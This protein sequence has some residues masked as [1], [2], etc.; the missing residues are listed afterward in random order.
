MRTPIFAR[1]G[2][3]VGRART[4]TAHTAFG[5]D[6]TIGDGLAFSVRRRD[7]CATI[8]RDDKSV[9]KAGVTLGA[10]E[11]GQSRW[12]SRLL[13][14]GLLLLLLAPFGYA[15]GRALVELDGPSP[16]L[17]RA[18]V[19]TQGI[20]ELPEG[21][22]VWRVVRR[23]APALGDAKVGRRVTSF[24]LAT[25]E[26]I[27]ITDAHDDGTFEDVARLAPGESYLTEN[28]TRQIRASLSGE[29]TQYLAIELVPAERGT[30]IGNGELLFVSDPFV[31]PAGQ[32]DLDL[33]RNVLVAGD[34]AQVPN[35]DGQI[36]V[37]A[38]DGAID[39]L[40]DRSGD[41]VIQAGE[42]A[43]FNAEEIEI[44]PAESVHG[45][46]RDELVA[47]TSALQAETPAAAYVIAVIGAEVPKTGETPSPSA[48]SGTIFFP[49][50]TPVGSTPGEPT[51]IAT[52][53]G[54]IGVRGRLCG[55]GVTIE[56]ISDAACPVIGDGFDM[57]LNNDP[58]GLTFSDATL[59]DGIWSWSGLPLDSY[60]LTTTRFPAAATDYLIPG[61]A[62]VG[63][64]PASGYT[65]TIDPTA[66]EIVLTA[67][68]LQPAQRATTSTTTITISICGWQNNAPANCQS[69]AESEVD[70]QPSL[71]S[72]SGQTVSWSE[73]SVSGGSYTWNLPAGTW[74]LA[75]AGWPY[76]YLVNGQSYNPN[77]P[78]SFT[79]DGANPVSIQVQ[80]VYPII[81]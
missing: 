39:I 79:T 2:V 57:T 68:F 77:A 72:S 48:E 33:I 22:A 28:G 35:T 41:Q 21:E 26:P 29:S 4:F 27:L 56:T 9:R 75:Q 10:S 6:E 58:L 14:L 64:S 70:P 31:T 67:Y 42:S 40:A 76:G 12:G 50:E 54:S 30:Q 61:S 25:D 16:A 45:E 20:S 24:A 36:M 23:T 66:P 1:L 53:T 3:P 78:Y 18:Q 71:T 47:L 38:T 17:G 65:V 49:T 5:P 73:A 46:P 34:I 15:A 74:T 63:G 69:P 37:L 19:I 81:Q 59:V 13:V 52:A 7:N 62:A 8:P 80:N 60:G 11:H 51:S 32:R 44:R 55:P 43:V